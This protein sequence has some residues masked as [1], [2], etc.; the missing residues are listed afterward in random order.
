VFLQT[1]NDLHMLG[2]KLVTYQ[3]S[4]VYV[5]TEVKAFLYN[6]KSTVSIKSRNLT[7]N[8]GSKDKSFYLKVFSVIPTLSA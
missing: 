6:M 5:I 2:H 7:L 4:G 8:Y 3:T 1:N